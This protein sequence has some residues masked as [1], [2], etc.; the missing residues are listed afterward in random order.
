MGCCDG[1]A[2][3]AGVPQGPAAHLLVQILCCFSFSTAQ[4]R[5]PLAPQALILISLLHLSLGGKEQL[6]R[7]HGAALQGTY[8]FM[9]LYSFMVRGRGRKPKA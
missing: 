7:Q 5:A 9:A 2:E 8:S 4:Q 6:R 3:A 1:Q